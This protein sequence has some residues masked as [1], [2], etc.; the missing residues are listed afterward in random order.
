[1]VRHICDRVAVM[2]L[3]IIVELSPSHELYENPLHPYT[4]ALLSSVPIPDPNIEEQ[5]RRSILKGEIPSPVDPPSGC[6]FRTRCP[7]VQPLCA[8]ETPEMREVRAGHFVA[9]HFC[10]VPETKTASGEER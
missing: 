8:E 6:R 2:Y 7:I 5:R 3:G 9:C 10:R 1:M 4:Q